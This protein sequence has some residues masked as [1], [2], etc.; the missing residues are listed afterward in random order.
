VNIV[1][2]LWQSVKAH[3]YPAPVFGEAGRAQLGRG[4]WK[5]RRQREWA[6]RVEPMEQRV[7][8]TVLQ[9]GPNIF[10]DGQNK[11]ITVTLNGNI[12]AEAFGSDGA[13]LIDLT[14]VGPPP[15]SLTGGVDIFAIYITSSD[16]NSS[17]TV[18][19]FNVQG[20]FQ[21]DVYTGGIASLFSMAQ[22]FGPMVAPAGAGQVYIGEHIANGKAANIPTVTATDSNG[23]LTGAAL[24]LADEAMA[25]VG[26]VPGV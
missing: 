23:L 26:E 14:P 12:T 2:R 20:G 19:S 21:G 13:N 1:Q 22:G 15:V 6:C 18:T 5:S 8:L 11:I 10:V 3:G 4:K 24:T 7:M 16:I 25:F 17:L 9:P